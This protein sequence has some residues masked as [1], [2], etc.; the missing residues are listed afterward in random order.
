MTLRIT[1]LLFSYE[2]VLASLTKP[3][4]DIYL[5]IVQSITPSDACFV[6]FQGNFVI[7]VAGT[8]FVVFMVF[9]SN[10]WDTAQ[11]CGGYIVRFPMSFSISGYELKFYHCGNNDTVYFTAYCSNSLHTH[12]LLTMQPT[13]M[14]M[15]VNSGTHKMQLYSYIHSRPRIKICCPH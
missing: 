6:V 5:Q 4:G 10:K 3:G 9:I 1:N 7:P 15:Q 14:S 13:N 2:D 8:N 12:T 11:G